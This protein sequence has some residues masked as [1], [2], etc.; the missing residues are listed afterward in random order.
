ML[1]DGQRRYRGEM[2]RSVLYISAAF[3]TFAAGV[4][5]ASLFA[6]PLQFTGRQTSQLIPQTTE[7]LSQKLEIAPISYPKAKSIRSID[8]DNF[9][10]PGSTYGQRGGYTP[11]QT[12]TLKHGKWGD[13]RDGLTLKKV[14]YGDVTGDGQ[15]EAILTFDQDTE[16]SAGVSNVYIYTLEKRR[17]KVLWAFESGDRADGGLRRI[18]VSQGK[19]VVE[20]YGKETKIEGSET[21]LTTE[22]GGLCCPKSFTRTRYEW[23]NER[24]RQSGGMEIFP[25]PEAESQK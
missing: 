4:V 14:I 24:F 6:R 8:F 1:S 9:T 18:S 3:L 21:T 17:P 13:W 10:Y 25:N 19:L 11:E 2:K 7:S 5:I 12:F 15:E 16:G 23:I 22:F 20:L